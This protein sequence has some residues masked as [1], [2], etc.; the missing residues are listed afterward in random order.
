MHAISFCVCCACVRTHAARKLRNTLGALLL[1][2]DTTHR[3]VSYINALIYERVCVCVRAYVL[4]YNN[5]KY[6]DEHPADVMRVRLGA[7]V[8]ASD[9]SRL[10]LGTVLCDARTSHEICTY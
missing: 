9:T 4:V 8:F 1:W 3:R 5:N 7:R 2:K 10:P 6:H